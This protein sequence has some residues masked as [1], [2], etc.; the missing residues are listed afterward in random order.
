MRAIFLSHGS[1]DNEAADRLRRWLE[2]QG[3]RSF[4]LD[5]DP[6]QGIPADRDWEK[7]L[8]AQLRTCRAIIV[9]CSPHSMASTWC[10]AEIT[11]ARALGKAI[12]P[13]K[14]ADCPIHSLLTTLQVLDL[15]A[16]KRNGLDRLAHWL[17][18]FG[19]GPISRFAL[20]GSRPPHPGLL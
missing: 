17:A 4:F 11:H 12:F 15:T 3:Y 8:Y 18:V 9:L 10:F 1:A 19:P 20:E 5:F 7:E 13:V 2:E 16:G 6:E 14:I